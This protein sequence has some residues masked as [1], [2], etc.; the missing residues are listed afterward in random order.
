MEIIANLSVAIENPFSI[1]VSGEACKDCPSFSVCLR[2][3]NRH[4]FL[5]TQELPQGEEHWLREMGQRRYFE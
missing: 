1:T 2:H 5:H 3:G 4:L